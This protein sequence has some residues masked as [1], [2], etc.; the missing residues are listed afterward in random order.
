MLDNIDPNLLKN[1]EIFDFDLAMNS[2]CFPVE[3]LVENN[4]KDFIEKKILGEFIN[5]RISY[6]KQ[7]YQEMRNLSHKLKSV[8]QMLGAIRLHKY[9]EQIQST[10]DNNE[11]NNIKQFYI[12]LISEMNIFIKELQNFCININY[13]I[14]ESLIEKYEQMMKECD[15]NDNNSKTSQE[16]TGVTK[17][18]EKIEDNIIDIE[19]GNIQIETPVKNTCCA[20]ECIIM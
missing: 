13:P 19:K 12:T 11:I 6:S 16:N 1:G 9:L 2:Y 17:N 10:I 20:I 4:F 18:N 3:D 8:F 7:D 15:L 5:L 14:D